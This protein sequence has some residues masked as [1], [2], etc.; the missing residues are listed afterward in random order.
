MRRPT[1]AIEFFVAVALLSVC[2]AASAADAPQ[3]TAGACIPASE[4][5]GRQF[6]C[7]ILAAQPIGKLDHPTFWHVETFATREAAQKVK[8]AHGA[9]LEAFDKIWLLTIADAGW[10]S[11]LP[12]SFLAVRRWS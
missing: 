4:R 9:V 1:R 12:I 5:A 3:D 7:F 2:I 10:R 11:D 6:G 8:D